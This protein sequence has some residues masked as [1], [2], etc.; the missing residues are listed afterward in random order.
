M[1]SIFGAFIRWWCVY[2]RRLLSLQLQWTISNNNMCLRQ[3]CSNEWVC[4]M[5]R[6]W[7]SMASGITLTEHCMST[8]LC[9][10]QKTNGRNNY[11]L[12]LSTMRTHENNNFN[13]QFWQILRYNN[14]LHKISCRQAVEQDRLHCKCICVSIK[15]Y[16]IQFMDGYQGDK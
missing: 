5:C 3:P 4:W 9:G 15:L 13:T 8:N 12:F 10:R 14:Q 16:S 1:L 2:R 6:K 7:Q 11:I